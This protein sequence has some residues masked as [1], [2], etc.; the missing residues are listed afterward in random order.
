M[1]L[2]KHNLKFVGIYKEE[3][4]GGVV[5]PWGSYWPGL[6]YSLY[7]KLILNVLFSYQK[8]IIFSL[9]DFSQILQSINIKNHLQDKM[10][11]NLTVYKESNF[12]NMLEVGVG[13]MGR[14]LTYVVS[15]IW[16]QI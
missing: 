16:T 9:I 2:W 3:Q 1:L 11:I 5:L 14:N 15:H 12:K 8:W 13:C 10:N 4:R 7:K 6:P